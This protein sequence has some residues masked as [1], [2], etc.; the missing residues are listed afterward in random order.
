[1]SMTLLHAST[2]WQL[3]ECRVALTPHAPMLIDG[4]KH[5]NMTF[6][7]ALDIAESLAAGFY[8]R[9]IGSGSQVT[10]M[11]PTG[12]PAVMTALALARLGALQ[13]PIISLYGEREVHNILERNRS[14][15]L[16]VPD[17]GER[18]F[19]AM[20]ERLCQQ[21]ERSPQLIVMGNQLP[22][23]RASSLPPPPSAA[24]SGRC[25]ATHNG[26]RR[27]ARS[28][29]LF[30]PEG[31]SRRSAQDCG[32]ALPQDRDERDQ[33]DAKACPGDPAFDQPQRV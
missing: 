26:S 22:R 17:R 31:L 15:F 16:L 1:M 32:E 23:G 29:S 7:Q 20:A 19:P 14:D 18:D 27:T 2:L 5:V 8:E 9:G 12:L 30:S 24:S 4:R 13:N 6:A 21:L 25:G 28:S 10:W 3:L 11:L 33:R